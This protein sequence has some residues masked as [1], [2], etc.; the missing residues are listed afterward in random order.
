MSYSLL[1]GERERETEKEKDACDKF[2]RAK[3][4]SYVVLCLFHC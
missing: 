1:H 4:F 2:D 3:L